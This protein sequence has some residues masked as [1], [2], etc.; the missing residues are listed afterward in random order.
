M[1]KQKHK[2][3]RYQ[4]A[5]NEPQNNILLEMMKEDAQTDISSFFGIV[6]VNEWKKREEIKAKRPQGRPRKEEPENEV[7]EQWDR[8]KEY[9][10][11]LPKNIK[12]YGK[13]IGAREYADVD[14]IKD[15]IQ[16]K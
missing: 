1:P 4:V 6:L 16:P 7:P 11:D 12:Y 5:L 15:Y 8:E 13:M 9:A 14:K 10:D 2:I 3:A